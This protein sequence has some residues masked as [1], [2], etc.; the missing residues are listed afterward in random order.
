PYL[1]SSTHTLMRC[2]NALA[3]DLPHAGPGAGEDAFGVDAARLAESRYQA[4]VLRDLYPGP[5]RPLPPP[6]PAWLV[7]NDRTIPRLARGIYE[8]RA[9]DRLPILADA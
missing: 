9:F 3:P 6:R 5:C 4:G 2:Q 7:W 8:E 1:S